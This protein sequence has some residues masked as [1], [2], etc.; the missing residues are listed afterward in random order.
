MPTKLTEHDVWKF[1]VALG[2]ADRGLSG[3]WWVALILRG[4]LPAPRIL[5]AL[6]EHLGPIWPSR[7]TLGGVPL[8]DTWRHP[9]IKRDDPTNGLV[10]IHKLSQ[11]LAYS[12]IEPLQDADIEVM[13]LDALTALAEYRNGGLL[14]DSGVLVPKRAAVLGEAHAAD[15]EV[16]VEWRALTVAL[17]D[18]LADLVRARLGLTPEQLPLAKILQGGTWSA[19]RA[20]ARQLRADGSPPLRVLSDGTLF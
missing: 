17:I 6:L 15:S 20:L 11:W 7:L 8:G 19:G 13:D 5:G 14:I 1:F 18:R 4:I 16:V 3:A 12:L 10:P 2:R 9:A